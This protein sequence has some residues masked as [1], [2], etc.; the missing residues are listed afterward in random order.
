VFAEDAEA[1]A[2]GL[3]VRGAQGAL[4]AR[5]SRVDDHAIPRPQVRHPGADLLDQ[6][7]RVGTDDVGEGEGDPG[8][9]V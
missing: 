6:T 1:A 3:L 7:G 2:V 4:A 8:E 9:A 5:D